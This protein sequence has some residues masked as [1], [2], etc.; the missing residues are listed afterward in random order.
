MAYYEGTIFAPG[1]ILGIPHAITILYI[2]PSL[3]W[4][5]ACSKKSDLFECA[6]D[7]ILDPIKRHFNID[8]KSYTYDLIESSKMRVR[9]MQA[10][11]LSLNATMQPGN[12]ELRTFSVRDNYELMSNVMKK[13]KE[14]FDE[15]AELDKIKD[16]VEHNTPFCEKINNIVLSYACT[17]RLLDCLDTY[18]AL[19]S[20]YNLSKI[21]PVREN[22]SD[23]NTH[24]LKL[25]FQ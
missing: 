22:I 20:Y 14:Q 25:K 2:I 4:G 8:S 17:S 15:L 21:K 10:R 7:V 23:L 5:I 18:P 24:Q 16:I 1:W 19:I 12:I 3:A 9:E 11:I 6:I 13:C